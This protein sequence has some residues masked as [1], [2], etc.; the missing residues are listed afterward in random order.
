MSTLGPEQ[1]RLRPYPLY[2]ATLTLYRL[3]P[4]YR[5]ST[6]PLLVNAALT[7]HAHHLKDL[8]AGE[9]LR[10]VR[11]GLAV[12][13]DEGL[14]RAGKLKGCRWK[15]LGD[16]ASWIERERRLQQGANG[17][18]G[19][20]MEA[21]E[22][23][24][25][26]PET[27]RGIHVEV[28]YEKITYMAVLLQD[29]SSL[30]VEE[31]H[32]FTHLPL[33]AMRMPGPLRET[34]LEYLSTA[35]DTHTSPLKLSSE[36]LISSLERFL[37]EITTPNQDDV[38]D[39][40][41]HTTQ[42]LNSLKNTVRD[43]AVTLSFTTP[44]TPSLKSLDI[45]ISKADVPGFIAYGKR[46]Q[47]PSESTE[48]PDGVSRRKRNQPTPIAASGPF[49]SALSQYTKTHL[50]FSLTHPDI[51]ISKIACG[52]FALGADGRVKIFSPV[53]LETAGEAPTR[54]HIATAGLLHG[55]IQ[56][57]EAVGGEA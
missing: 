41:E 37:A 6:S 39:A 43:L 52:A 46:L 35:F 10:G 9:V 31:G 12:A 38:D 8:L 18:V 1:E 2:N 28:E 55:L 40:D 49:A 34:F 56:R 5:A 42:M 4:L 51:A 44:V 30:A 14:A 26:T 48:S 47:Q 27:I 23:E 29:T 19:D 57:A 11:V 25:F 16:E 32:E 15:V 3:S 53:G 20:I 54:S 21:D 36:F 33:L 17:T 24:E 22:E 45:T 7:Q 13:G 50:A